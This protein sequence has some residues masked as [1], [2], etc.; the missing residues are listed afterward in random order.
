VTEFFL[1]QKKGLRETTKGFR[2]NSKFLGRDLNTGIPEHEAESSARA[3]GWDNSSVCGHDRE[4]CTAV[5]FLTGAGTVYSA[6]KK[7]CD[8]VPTL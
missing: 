2:Q 6:F 1:Y 3:C 5:L 7:I 4:Q 8:L